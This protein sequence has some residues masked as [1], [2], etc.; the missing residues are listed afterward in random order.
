[1]ALYEKRI[2]HALLD[3]YE[4][5]LLSRKENKVAVHICFPVT[6]KTMPE[7]FDESSLA[8]EDIHAC[9]REMECKGFVTVQWKKGKEDHI[10]Q[11]ILLREENADIIYRYVG[12]IPKIKLENNTIKLLTELEEKYKTP[13]ATAFLQ[14]LTARISGGQSVKEYIDLEDKQRIHRLI[15][16]VAAIEANEKTCY[17]RE[18]SIRLFGD[19]KE[20]ESLLGV[21]GKIFRRF[22]GKEGETDNYSIL[23]D[24]SI[25]H[26]PDYV[27]LKGEGTLYFGENDN[28]GLELSRLR[29]GIGVSGED[30]GTLRIRSKPTTR[31]VITIENLTTF[32]G[33]A[34]E[35]SIIIYLGG[36]HN[37]VRRKLLQSIHQHMPTAQYLHFGDID[38]G[39]FEIY[40]DLCRK[41]QITFQPYHMGIEEL[42]TYARYAKKLTVNDR[43]RLDELIEKCTENCE[44]R[45]VLDYMKEKGI[46]L[47]QECVQR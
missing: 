29:Q 12:R 18:F 23:A 32:F 15:K 9:V 24:Y 26:T 7:Y 37:T 14:Y 13:T 19:S 44:Y 33:W 4:N 42:K 47:E 43:K 39:G 28:T 35:D 17:I 10:L 38:V 45:D 27:Y 1:M 21:T 5:S 3:S 34:E 46:K 20:M 11:K 6:K 41:T 8:Y 2:L 25:Y 36:Y 30:I 31:K 22:G 16:A 40:E